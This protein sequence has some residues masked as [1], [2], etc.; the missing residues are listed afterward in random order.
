MTGGAGYIGSSLVK[1]LL[2]H[3]IAT[4]TLDIAST[5]S[6]SLQRKP[7]NA[8]RVRGGI[9]DPRAVRRA[10]SKG[11]DVVVHLAAIPNP[12]RC[13][14]DPLRA[15]RT[16]ISGT[17]L[18]LRESSRH[19]P[20]FIFA[21]SQ[22]VYGDL[23]NSRASESTHPNPKDLYSLTKLAGE[24]MVQSYDRANLVRGV[25]LRISSVYGIGAWPNLDQIPGRMVVDCIADRTMTL[26]SSTNI[27]T[28]GG[29][30]VDLVHVRDVCNAILKVIGNRD[31]VAGQVFNISSG[32]G[33][34]VREVAGLVARVS[35]RMGNKGK[36]RYLRGFRSVEMVRS[37]VLSNAKARSIVGWQP[38]ISL[39][40]G[41]EEM[42]KYVQAK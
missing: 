27:R 1:I 25:I 29:Q 6:D 38:V 33:V 18:A 23:G 8:R 9:S 40:R 20:L 41:V 31:R 11:A 37:L 2:E 34:S 35:R 12:A 4:T 24:H 14:A 42:V 22:T 5:R 19:H 10:L 17:E 7:Q 3:N 30:V 28:P 21:S 16:N 36:V 13:D 26:I 39:R 32:K 15:L